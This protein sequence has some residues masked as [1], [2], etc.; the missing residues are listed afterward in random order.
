MGRVFPDFKIDKSKNGLFPIHV[1]IDRQGFIWV[2]LD[3]SETPEIAWEDDFAGI[4]QQERYEQFNF[5]DYEFDHVWQMDG[6]YNWKILADNYNECYHCAT[7]H[8]D[9]PAVANLESYSVDTKLG[10]IVHNP[11]TTEEQREKGLI[12]AS[13]YYFPNVSTNIT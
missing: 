4:D 3:G 5:D 13:T 2:N 10:Q 12:V 7:T 11:A 8:P 6:T 9:I 1:H